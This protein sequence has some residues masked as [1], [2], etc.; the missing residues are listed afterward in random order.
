MNDQSLI[1]AKGLEV[2]FG[3]VS[4]LSGANV[5]VKPGEI[6][7]IIGPNGAGKTTLVKVM[8]GLIQPQRGTV[9]R[10]PKLH[11]GYM[12][13]R[14]SIDP[15]MPITVERFL[16]MGLQGKVPDEDCR[17]VMEEVGAIDVLG[18][19]MQSISG[20]E[21]QRVLL[22]RALLRDP[23]L[24]VLDEPVQGVDITGQA[25][26]YRLI[27]GIRKT[28]NVGVVMVSHDLHVVMAQTDHVLCLNGHVCCAGHPS[29]VSRHPEFVAMFGEDVASTL[30]VYA[31]NHDHEHGLDGH[32]H[33][34]HCDHE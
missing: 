31:H 11:I 13:Q 29:Q 27:Q 24:L 9:Q 16:R 34:E 4:V 10:K 12:P 17:S 1:E 21:M 23:E 14:L 20:G 22:A 32:V 7:T 2:A 28:R 3:D 15:A 6:V 26:L 18:H 25:D 30:A 19:P 33:G 8:L 5:S